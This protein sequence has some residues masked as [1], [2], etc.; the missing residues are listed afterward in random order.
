MTPRRPQGR[1]LEGPIDD[2]LDRCWAWALAATPSGP[3]GRKLDEAAVTVDQRA[4]RAEF[5]WGDGKR[6]RAE[7]QTIGFFA[8]DPGG[9]PDMVLF[10]WAWDDPAFEKAMIRH[11]LDLK[12]WGEKRRLGEFSTGAMRVPRARCWKFGA[13]AAALSGAAATVGCPVDG[14]LVLLTVGPL[15]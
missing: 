1:D 2:V 9:A 6:V 10:R 8:P 11:A 13:L 15:K 12:R 3:N 5:A 4:R 7:A 14:K